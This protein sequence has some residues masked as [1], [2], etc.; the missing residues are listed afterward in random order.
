MTP[1]SIRHPIIASP[2]LFEE[3]GIFDLAGLERYYVAMHKHRGEV[4]Q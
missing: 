2:L 1:L 3:S 4:G